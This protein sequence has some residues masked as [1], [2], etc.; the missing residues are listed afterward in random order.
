VYDETVNITGRMANITM[1]GDGSKR[2]IVT[3][4]K[5]IVDGVRMWR[6]ATFGMDTSLMD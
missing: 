4:S 2:S 5:N 3:G 6:T 1:Y